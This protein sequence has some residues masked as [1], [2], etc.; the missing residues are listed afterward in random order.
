MGAYPTPMGG[1]GNARYSHGSEVHWDVGLGTRSSLVPWDLKRS[2]HGRDDFADI[3]VPWES[4][5]VLIPPM[6]LRFG[7]IALPFSPLGTSP[8]GVEEVYPRLRYSA[9]FPKDVFGT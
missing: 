4:H 3:L 1:T 8:V 5:R 7:P 9:L 6:G 2:S